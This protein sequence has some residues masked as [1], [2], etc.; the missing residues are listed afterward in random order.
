[1]IKVLAVMWLSGVA[2]VGLGLG[3]MYLLSRD[4]FDHSSTDDISDEI[5]F[6]MLMSW[7]A[8]GVFLLYIIKGLL[9]KMFKRLK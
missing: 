9:S 4:E 1:M 8:V 7:A 6:L 2:V 5:I 3:V